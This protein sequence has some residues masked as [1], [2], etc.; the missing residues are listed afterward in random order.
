MNLVGKRHEN[1]VVAGFVLEV[2]QV[3]LFSRLPGWLRYL[4]GVT[5]LSNDVGYSVSELLADLG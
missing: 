2:V 1:S 4:E 5:A 3:R